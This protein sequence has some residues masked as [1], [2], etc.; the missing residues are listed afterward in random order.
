MILP[1]HQQVMELKSGAPH[2]ALEERSLEGL[3]DSQ[4]SALRAAM[5]QALTLIQGPP[6]T[7]KTTV[8]VRILRAWAQ[9]RP[10]SWGD[11][12]RDGILAA[13]DS[14]IAVDNIV[15]GLA[16]EGVRVIRLGRP[17]TA[18]PEL[19]ALCAEEIA[20]KRVGATGDRSRMTQE[21]KDR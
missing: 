7:G 10:P 13:S 3:N 16:K 11:G 1:L 21:E 15:E 17:E 14:N 20:A 6:G 4:Q 5:R 8:A 18:R 19:L 12:R 2:A 9:S